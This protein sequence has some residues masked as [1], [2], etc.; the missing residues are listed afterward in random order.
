MSCV[1][2]TNLFVE[3]DKKTDSLCGC[4]SHTSCIYKLVT[5][6]I[7]SWER[8]PLSCPSCFNIVYERPLINRRTNESNLELD[9]LNANTEFKNELKEI[10]KKQRKLSKVH[11]VFKQYL[12]PK[13]I[14]FKNAITPHI[15]II[16]GIHTQ[17]K[18]EVKLDPSYKENI[19]AYSSYMLS[20]GIFCR[21]YDISRESLKELKLYTQHRSTLS[22][23]PFHLI[24]R[25]FALRLRLW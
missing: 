24:K 17:I 7:E 21:K 25:L 23:S 18:K 4:I 14:S 3:G 19:K 6:Y 2:C 15:N 10:K 8:E 20:R 9:Q 1:V 16:K 22:Y 12:K 13:K 5:D 11:R